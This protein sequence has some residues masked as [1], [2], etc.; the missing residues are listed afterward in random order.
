MDSRFQFVSFSAAGLAG[1]NL[2]FPAFRPRFAIPIFRRGDCNFFRSI[3]LKPVPPGCLT[4]NFAAA[5]SGVPVSS[6]PYFCRNTFPAQT[7]GKA[8]GVFRVCLKILLFKYLKGLSKPLFQS[9]T[10]DQQKQGQNTTVQNSHLCQPRTRQFQLFQPETRKELYP[11][12]QP[13]SIPQL[14][15]FA[16]FCNSVHCSTA[17]QLFY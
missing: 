12:F 5:A 6:C 4:V 14:H 16:I 10:Q 13:F 11:L 2:I 1:L 17:K 3:L 15:F 7:A 9:S 8:L